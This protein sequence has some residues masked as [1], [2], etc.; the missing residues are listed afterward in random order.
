MI[1]PTMPPVLRTLL[2]LLPAI[3]SFSQ[4][5]ADEIVPVSI[6]EID[7]RIAGMRESWGVP[8]L[9]VA[10][11]KDGEV[12]LAKGYGVR[13]LGKPETVDADTLFAIASNTKAFTAAAIAMLEEEDKL[14][15]NDK[16]QQHLPYFQL[17]DPWVS[18]EMR[19]DDLLCHRSGLGTFSG[20]LLWWGTPWTPEE[21]IRRTRHLKPEGSFRAHYGYSNLMF[22]AAGEVIVKS[23]GS[24]WPEFIQQRIFQPL[25]MTR[26]VTTIRNLSQIENVATPHKPDL[27][28]TRPIPWYN[29]DTMAAAG[30]IISSVNDM[31]KWLKVQLNRGQ[32]DESRRLFSEA[33][34]HRMW[35]S[36]TP[37]TV[38]EAA[39]RKTPSTH[40]RSY[41]LGWVLHDYKGQMV[42]SHGGGYDGM[43]SYVA[44]VPEQKLG[45]VVL[46]NSMT[47]VSTPIANHI[48]DD[49]LGGEKRNWDAEGLERD[50]SSRTEFYER[51]AK[52]ISPKAE[53]TQP[54]HPLEAYTGTFTG[55]LYGDA[56]VTQEESGLVLK[57]AANPDLVADLKHL[58]FDT[59]VI[60][61]RK[62]S[63]WFREGTA[64][65][66]MNADG[67][68]QEI[69]LDVPNDDLWFHELE[70]KKKP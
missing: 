68:I 30:G 58:H 3:L 18:A 64:L 63:A 51:I 12:V 55:E 15:W 42:V 25:E 21:V 13:E 14:E 46:T 35:S 9:A 56:T 59:F 34:S 48:I 28:A 41:G 62:E 10:I 60:H 53:N 1:F 24:S 16:V 26:S 36:H 2:M 19:V 66:Q 50:K 23:S 4:L 67:K 69:R 65:F 54:S 11:I 57:F 38:S 43:Y 29:W 32:I 47:G 52:A 49:Y 17:Y 6:E 33:S 45:I 44:M 40:F 7:A 37:M 20:D 8:G 39:R 70:L 5:V 31:S 27:E 22:L 61:W